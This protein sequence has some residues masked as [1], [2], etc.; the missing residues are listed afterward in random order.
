MI[1]LKVQKNIEKYIGQNVV[2]E[3]VTE[4][5]NVSVT[6]D[7]ITMRQWSDF[8]LCR[9]KLPEWFRDMESLSNDEMIEYSATFD[10]AKAAAYMRCVA[11]LVAC[12]CDKPDLLRGLPFESSKDNSIV[13]LYA[14]IAQSIYTY[15]AK[16]R[17][18]FT[19]KGVQF[20]FPKSV[21]DSF[22]REWTG[23]ELTTGESIEAL[24]SSHVLNAR[25]EFGEYVLGDRKYHTDVALLASLARKVG[26][27]GTIEQVPIE[28]GAMRQFFD[29][30]TRFFADVSMN[31]ALDMAFFLSSSRLRSVNILTSALLIKALQQAS[32]KG[33][34]KKGMSISG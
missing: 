24:Q 18:S 26:E 27:D 28:T 13:A 21:I 1:V 3:W 32:T 20:V 34:A 30:R 15:E 16:P 8:W 9:A 11:E 17:E 22:G 5:L 4:K 29:E 10:E 2:S 14:R 25:N 12:F 19:H 6:P 7:F 31:I 33:N 23:Q